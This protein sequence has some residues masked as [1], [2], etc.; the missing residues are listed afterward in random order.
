M[1][2]CTKEFDRERD[3]LEAI[4]MRGNKKEI[5]EKL[6]AV[7]KAHAD[8]LLASSQYTADRV[9]ASDGYLELQFV[10]DNVELSYEPDVLGRYYW[11]AYIRRFFGLVRGPIRIK[12]MM[13]IT[14]H[15]SGSGYYWTFSSARTA[16]L[17]AGHSYPVVVELELNQK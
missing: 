3:E 13:G 12:R 5:F 2:Y 1:G 8:Y 16:L 4:A 11:W 6:K 9:M 7:S 15:L 17:S 10:P 14:T